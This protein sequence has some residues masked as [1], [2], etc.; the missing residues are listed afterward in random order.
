MNIVIRKSAAVLKLL[1]GKDET[2]LI[3]WDTFLVL[4]LGPAQ[5]VKLMLILGLT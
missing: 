4:D 3:G 2:L 1:S 5:M